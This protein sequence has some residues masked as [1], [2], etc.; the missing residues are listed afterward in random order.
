MKIGIMGAGGV[1]G[2]VGGILAFEGHEVT[3]IA[4]GEHL[5]AMK[6]GGLSIRSPR[7]DFRIP[8]SDLPCSGKPGTAAASDDSL[9]LSHRLGQNGKV[10]LMIVAVKTYQLEEARRQIAPLIGAQTMILPLENGVD[11]SEYL[12]EKYSK[13]QVLRGL[14]RMVSY[15]SAPGEIL[16][17]GVDPH[18]DF[19]EFDGGITPRVQEMAKILSSPR[20]KFEIPSDLASAQWQKF[21]FISSLGAISALIRLPIGKVRRVPG[22]RALITRAMME[23]QAVG[24]AKGVTFP[25][26]ALTHWLGHL[27]RMPEDGSTSM[28]RDFMAGRS[29]EIESFSGYVVKKGLELAVPTPIHQTCYDL[30]MPAVLNRG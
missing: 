5:K 17:A 24:R 16:H 4:R 10:D 7:G 8:I 26:T 30:L 29:I 2:L 9:A 13:N 19:G 14:C 15:V 20:M 21:M 25:E 27:D 6:A 18:I 12:A 23:V 3:F 11:S 28:Q 1:G 22:T